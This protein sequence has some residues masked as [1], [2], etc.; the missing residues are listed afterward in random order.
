MIL[1][2]LL[3]IILGGVVGFGVSYLTRSIGSS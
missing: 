1:K 2:I 3:G